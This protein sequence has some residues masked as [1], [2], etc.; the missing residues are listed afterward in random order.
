MA[1]KIASMVQ[2]KTAFPDSVLPKVSFASHLADAF[3]RLQDAMV[4]KI[5]LKVKT[6]LIAK[7][8]ERKVVLQI[9]SNVLMENVCLNM[10][11]AMPSL[12]VVME[13]MNQLTSV[14]EGLEGGYQS[15]VL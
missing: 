6:K 14:E 1:E 8:L 3:P 7:L 5:A 11:S 15:T 4:L 2:M 13:A 9:P 10:S 12:A